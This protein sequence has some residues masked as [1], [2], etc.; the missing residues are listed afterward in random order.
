[1]II[2]WYNMICIWYEY[3]ELSLH[4]DWYA[5]FSSGDFEFPKRATPAAQDLRFVTRFHSS[6]TLDISHQSHLS[7]VVRTLQHTSPTNLSVTAQL[8]ASHARRFL[9]IELSCLDMTGTE[10]WTD[11]SQGFA[12]FYIIHRV[13]LVLVLT[14]ILIG[15]DKPS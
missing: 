6:K 11:L 7:F 5:S 13:V 8:Q 3:D 2:I 4:R 15:R 1:M 14:L 12:V 9:E 10:S